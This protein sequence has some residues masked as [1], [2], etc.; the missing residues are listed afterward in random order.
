MTCEVT[1]A[2]PAR[3]FAFVTGRP[4]KPETVWRYVLEPTFQLVKRLGAV[5]NLV[6]RVTTGGGAGGPTWGTTCG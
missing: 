2:E 4:A 1:A 6:T 3:E 5:S